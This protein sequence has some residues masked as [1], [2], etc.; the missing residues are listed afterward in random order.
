VPNINEAIRDLNGRL[1]PIG[2]LKLLWR[3]KVRFPQTVRL[4][5]LGVRKEYHD[6]LLGAALPFLMIQAAWA[7]A[8]K[9][10]VKKAELS[11]I[12]EDNKGISDIIES[13]GGT[14]HKTYRIYAKDLI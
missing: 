3:L 7:Y 2:W 1:L 12:L 8:V 14:V 13:L 6:S 4:P 10:G 11:W 5:F 9:R